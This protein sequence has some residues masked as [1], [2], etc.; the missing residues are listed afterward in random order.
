[1]IDCSKKT[2][3]ELVKLVLEDDEYFA[4]LVER[5]EKKLLRY[6]LRISDF[7][8]STAEDVLQ[9]VF[10]S[11]YRNLNDF[12]PDLSFSSWIYRITHNTVITYFRKRK[13]ESVTITVDPDSDRDFA[14]LLPDTLDLAKELDREIAI[15]N[16]GKALHQLPEKYR[17]VLFLRY[18]E[19]KSYKEI[20][21][22]LKKPVNSVS[23]LINRAKAKIKD[24]L[25]ISNQQQNV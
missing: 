18:M 5:Y 19:D 20:G 2:D 15:K 16:V 10:I 13:H 6:I 23:V 12:N 11:V 21:D 4:C 1:M 9:D 8:K 24:S 3:A 14:S 7:D 17:E 22:I 25:L